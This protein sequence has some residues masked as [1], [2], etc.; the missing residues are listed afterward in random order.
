MLDTMDE[1]NDLSSVHKAQDSSMEKS[2]M[3]ADAEIDE[4]DK[5]DGMEGL[6]VINDELL[7]FSVLVARAGRDPIF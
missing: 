3:M 7:V 5:I 4:I 2:K 1:L 6:D